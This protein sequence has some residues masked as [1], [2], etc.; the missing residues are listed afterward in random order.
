MEAIIAIFLIT[1]GIVGTYTLITQT[2]SSATFSKDKL[3]AAYLAQEGIEIVRNIR[4]TNWLQGKSWDEGLHC[5]YEVQY[6]DYFVHMLPC[7]P[8]DYDDLRLLKIDGGFYN[9]DSG[10]DTI[11]KRVI[12]LDFGPVADSWIYK[13]VVFWKEGGKIYKVEAQEILYNW[14]I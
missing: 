5:S 9:Y 11:F 2:I 10:D 7:W 1:V 12:I 13:V 6:S 14:K 4:D 3:I 8:C